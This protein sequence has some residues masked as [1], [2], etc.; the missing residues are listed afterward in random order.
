MKKIIYILTTILTSGLFYSCNYLDVVPDDVPTLEHSFSNRLEA[1]RF[2]F[3][4]Y[5][6]IPETSSVNANIGL[7]GA[8]EIWTNRYKENDG[9]RVAQGQ[10]N[11]NDPLINY[12]EGR[13]GA[14]VNLYNGIRDC[15]IFL[16]I[17]EDESRIPDLS[18]TMRRRWIAEVKF[19]KA[20]YH[21][22]LPRIVNE[23]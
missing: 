20:Y 21:F 14:N 22:Y 23:H 17:L 6:Y 10:Q 2:L 19:L 9:L 16:E 13:R 8:D 12:W 4:C 3:T 7:C 11:T 1:E 15:N 5:S 18:T